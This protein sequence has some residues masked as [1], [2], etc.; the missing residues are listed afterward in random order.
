ME[1]RR[2]V[3]RKLCVPG[4]PGALALYRDH[5]CGEA[6]QR[7]GVKRFR[8][9]WTPDRVKKTRQNKKLEPGSDLV[10]TGKALGFTE[11]CPFHRNKGGSARVSRDIGPANYRCEP[12]PAL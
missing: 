5:A 6:S 3:R 12:Y 9:K 4:Q 10:R 2:V 7:G 8:A 11:P 1:R